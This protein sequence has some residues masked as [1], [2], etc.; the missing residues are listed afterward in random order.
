MKAVILLLVSGILTAGV[1]IIGKQ[2]GSESIS[3]LQ[4]LFW[5]LSGGALVVW[6]FSWPS[7]NFPIWN[8]EHIRYYVIGGLLGISLP[9]ILAYVVL[10]ELQVGIVGLVTAL[11]P[12]M[13]YALARLL[14]S[15][16][17][18]PL[19]LLGL[20]AG[21]VGVALL[22]MPSEIANISGLDLS[23][24][25]SFMLL[26]LAIPVV[27]ATSNIY[28]SRF[29]PAGSE[30]MPL[31]IGMLTMQSLWLFIA[32]LLFGNFNQIIPESHDMRWLLF[33]LALMAGASYLTSFNLLKI[34]GPVYLSQMG[35][36]ITAVTLLA[37]I[38]IWGEHYDNSDILSMVLIL[39]GVLMTTWSG[40]N[41]AKK[42]A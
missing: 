22:V 3:P 31:V 28:R 36:V 35:Y 2:A 32:N 8:A 9:F 39:L 7:K 34:G 12:V 42:P 18:S 30:A 4:L 13:T 11:S 20:I 38:L 10:R 40:Y 23:R 17:S 1:F 33:M 25:G 41:R 14:G 15:E 26:A 16:R 27:L 37:G 24:Q 19:R 29:W 5:Q 6:F 21:L